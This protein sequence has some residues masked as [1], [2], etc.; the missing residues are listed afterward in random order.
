MWL[1]LVHAVRH[2]RRR[3]ALTAVAVVSLAVGIGCA[4]ACASVVNAV[5]FRAFPYRDPAR[6]VLVWENNAKRGVGLTP[7]SVLNYEDLKAAA[8]TF[9]RIGAFIDDDVTVDRPDG[10]ERAIGYRTTAGLLEQTGV[11]PV[12]GRLFSESED[13]PGAADVVVLSHGFW[14][15]CF[16][17][18]P[19]IAG[20]AIRLTGVPHTVVGVMPR[21]FVLPPVFGVRLVGT[22]IVMK[23]ADFWAPLKIDGLPRRRDARMLFV[24]GELK[25][26]RSLAESQ[27]EASAIARRLASDHPVDDFGMDFTIV[28]LEKQVLT[29][30]RTLLLLLVIVGGLVLVIA[31][32]N[33][34]HLR[35]VDALAMT[36]ETAVRSALGASPWRLASGQGALS[37]AWCTLATVA[38]LLVAAALAAP[39]AAY[40]RA[41]VPRLSEVQLDRTTGTIAIGLGAAL[42]FAIS[43]LPLAYAR[44][45]AVVR[46]GA[47]TPPAIGLPRWRR[48]FVV[49]QLAVAIMVLS[50]A[51]LLFRSAGALSKVNPGFVA[52]GV[53][54][55]ELLLPDTRYSSPA[56]RVNFQRRL[57]E[58]VTGLP[59]SRAS[60]TVD[61]LPFGGSSSIVNFTIE[62]HQPSDPT[63]KPRAALRAISASYFDVLSIPR[64]QGRGFAVADEAPDRQVVIVNE[65]F[66]RR[67]LPGATVIG[68]RMKRGEA[69]SQTPW[70]TIVGVVGSVHS[71]GL[72][73]EPQPEAFIPYVKGGRQ[74]AVSLILK[75]TQPPKAIAGAVRERILR[76]DPALPV[77]NVTEMSEL[78]DRTLSQPY[79]YARMFGVLGLAALILS[80]AGVYGIAAVGISARSP[81]IAIRS[82]LGAQRRD[83]VLLILRETATAASAAVVVGAFGALILQRRMAALVYGVQ[84]IDWWVIAGCAALMVVMA[85]GVVYMAIRQVLHLRPM[86]LLKHGAGA[87]A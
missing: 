55:Y 75:G 24:L 60:A 32:T 26:G 78:V 29:N 51:A 18:D 85:L 36:G 31:V 30:V 7:T 69:N 38:A 87:L 77:P 41:N 62:R 8:T 2:L 33:A 27:A 83:I 57:L 35:L 42:A 11:S 46:C 74:A 20:K 84:S 65:A 16:G 40:T 66:A 58:H 72:S 12:I 1:T 28:P 43:L 39:V 9:E 73:L 15:R 50:V 79:F 80:L 64:L 70:M 13:E 45:T 53:G 4:L 14:Q 81:E 3:P 49:V 61:Y 6:L 21:G 10:A 5:L 67:Y 59:D 25:S 19:A 23:E 17:S 63:V 68:R 34:A 47:S 71:A 37:L 82:C 22:E 76:T 86:D 56:A 52:R 54:V 48:I 44:R